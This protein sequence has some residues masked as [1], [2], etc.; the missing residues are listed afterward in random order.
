MANAVTRHAHTHANR[1][2]GE[3][4]TYEQ[5]QGERYASELDKAA[6]ILT[7]AIGRLE[8]VA[9]L[10]E[11]FPQTKPVQKTRYEYCLRCDGCGWYEGG[12]TIQTNCEKCGGTGVI[13]ITKA[14][15]S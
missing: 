12:P 15:G 3:K 11:M 10:E 5:E 9:A 8:V 14:S 2:E 4:M 6:D 1:G 13:A 7:R